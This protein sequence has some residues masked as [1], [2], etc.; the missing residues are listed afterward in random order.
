M[1]VLNTLTRIYPPEGNADYV[2]VILAHLPPLASRHDGS[3]RFTLWP[4]VVLP[5]VRDAPLQQRPGRRG[6]AA[7]QHRAT[8]EGYGEFDR[9]AAQEQHDTLPSI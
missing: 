8:Y 7:D 4:G 9:Q 2:N 6:A 1:G 3:G 5:G